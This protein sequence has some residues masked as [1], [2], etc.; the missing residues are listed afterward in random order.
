MESEDPEVEVLNYGV[1]GYGIDRAYLRYL[2]EGAELHPRVVMMGFTTDDIGRVVNVYR[3]FID[4]RSSVLFKPRFL[5]DAR[6]ELTLLEPPLKSR[7][8][9]GRLQ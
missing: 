4:S 5:I 8:D 9:Y 7:A 2:S 6:N 1:G 3:G